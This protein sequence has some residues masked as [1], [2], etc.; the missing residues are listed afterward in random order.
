MRIF[1]YGRACD[2][3]LRIGHRELPDSIKMV[4][5][6]LSFIPL[7]SASDRAA[8]LVQK[9]KN[10]L[11]EMGDTYP[12]GLKESHELQIQLLEDPRVP[13]FEILFFPFM[14]YF[15]PTPELEKPF[16]TILPTLARPFSRGSV[17]C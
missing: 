6:A 5:N 1:K 11:A 17:V 13:D 14:F 2:L 7:Q 15:F 12:Q 8:Q 10:K 3:V 4:T 9:Q 16:I